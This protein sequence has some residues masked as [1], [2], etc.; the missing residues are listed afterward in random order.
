MLNASIHLGVVLPVPE[1]LG[2]GFRPHD[3]D[4]IDPEV[5]N[6]TGFHDSNFEEGKAGTEGD[7]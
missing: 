7:D 4:P 6:Q 2:L 5:N 1:V 3:V